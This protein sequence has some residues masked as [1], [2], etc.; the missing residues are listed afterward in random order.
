MTFRVIADPGAA[1]DW[2]EAVMWYEERKPGVG[3]RLNLAIHATL[4]TLASQPERFPLATRQTHKAKVPPPWPYSAY[5]TINMEH[6]EVKVLAI[7]HGRH[8]PDALLRRLKWL[9]CGGFENELVRAKYDP[10]DFIEPL[11]GDHG[12]DSTSCRC[13]L[14]GGQPSPYCAS[15]AHSASA[16]KRVLDEPR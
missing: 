8:S 6:R 5:F 16:P 12:S 13:V 2:H 3:S 7:W 15:V 4:Q 9:V 10:V 1:R 11:A 14:W